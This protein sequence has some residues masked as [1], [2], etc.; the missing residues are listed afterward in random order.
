MKHKTDQWT[1]ARACLRHRHAE[2]MKMRSRRCT[3]HRH[4]KISRYSP[5]CEVSIVPRLEPMCPLNSLHVRWAAELAGNM[6]HRRHTAGCRRKKHL[7]RYKLPMKRFQMFEVCR[8]SELKCLIL[9]VWMRLILLISCHF[10][11]NCYAEGHSTMFHKRY[12]VHRLNC[13]KAL[14]LLKSYLKVDLKARSQQKVAQQNSP[15]NDLD[16]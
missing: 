16:L 14:S 12:T 5:W 8:G 3:A 6:W 10:F 4:T 1:Y 11:T 13:T 2:E 9:R 7:T 15:V